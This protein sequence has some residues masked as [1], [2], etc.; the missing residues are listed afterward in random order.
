MAGAAG[1]T[2]DSPTQPSQPATPTLTAPQNDSPSDDL[3]LSSL[4]PTLRVTNGTSTTSGSRT[5][6]FQ[7]A[8]S[9]AF[10]TIA[11]SG[12]GIAEDAS[13]KTSWAVSTALQPTTRYWWRA[14]ANQGSTTGP[15]STATRFR[16]R[17]QGYV[18]NG[19][20]YD[21]LVNG[22]TVGASANVTFAESGARFNALESL[23]TYALPQPLTAGEFSVR[24]T[25]LTTSSTGDKTKIFSMQEGQSDITDN[26]FRATIEKRFNGEISFRFISGDAVNGVINAD[27]QFLTFDPSMTYFWRFTWGNG[28]VRMLNAE[29]D[30]RGRVMFDQT[31]GYSG[32]YQPTPHFAYIGAPIP[33]GGADGA[34]VPGMV[35]KDVWLSSSPRPATLGSAFRP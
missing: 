7:V 12:A 32:T 6:E 9:D 13:G 20:L 17:V 16:S 25:G 1:C 4:Q 24:V 14:R 30:A 26:R 11:A 18:R 29:N 3:Q 35:V 28:Q 22:E 15:W 21:P 5:Y 33:R 23:I 19:E 31:K 27:R 10:T 34:S 8:A 2:K